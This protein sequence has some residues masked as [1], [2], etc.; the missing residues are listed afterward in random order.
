MCEALIDLVGAEIA[1]YMTSQNVVEEVFRDPPPCARFP[2]PTRY[3]TD[4]Q[5]SPTRVINRGV[6]IIRANRTNGHIRS[7]LQKVIEEAAS[8]KNSP[9]FSAFLV[10]FGALFK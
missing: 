1:L 4:N 8:G 2:V 6:E 10:C 5:T 9:K 3:V 7:E